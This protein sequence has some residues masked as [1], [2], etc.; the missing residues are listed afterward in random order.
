MR[1]TRSVIARRRQLFAPCAG[2]G[3]HMCGRAA[4]GGEGQNCGSASAD[5]YVP[6]RRESSTAASLARNSRFARGTRR[7]AVAL[8]ARPRP[9]QRRL[10]TR[11]SL[12]A[13]QYPRSCRCVRNGDVD[14]GRASVSG[15]RSRL[16]APRQRSRSRKERRPLARIS[17][18]RRPGNGR[19]HQVDSRFRLPARSAAPTR[20]RQARPRTRSPARSPFSGSPGPRRMR[21][22]RSGR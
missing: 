1:E 4:R 10:T 20:H 19:R 17:S 9:Y 15:S 16:R 11:C 21:W 13:R 3:T 14:S 7:A 2:E 18:D 6:T 22:P 12:E 5:R 8:A